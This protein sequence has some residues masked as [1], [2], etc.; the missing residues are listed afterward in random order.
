MKHSCDNISDLLGHAIKEKYNTMKIND[1]LI[2]VKNAIDWD[3]FTPLL[4]D[5]YQNDTDRGGRPNIPVITM[6]KVL[7]FQSIYNLVDDQTEKEVHDRISFMNFLDYADQ[8]PDTR[9]IWLFRERI[10]SY[11]MNYRDSL[12]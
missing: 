1:P 5:L 2:F 8:Y 12:N 6:V 3:A 11:G 10:E 4:N 7:Y 9:T